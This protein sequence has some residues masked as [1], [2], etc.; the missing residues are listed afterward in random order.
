MASNTPSHSDHQHYWEFSPPSYNGREIL[1]Q[2]LFWALLVKSNILIPLQNPP[3]DQVKALGLLRKGLKEDIHSKPFQF[4]HILIIKTALLLYP[5]QYM[6]VLQLVQ[7]NQNNNPEYPYNT[8]NYILNIPE[9]PQISPNT[10]KT[11]P[12]IPTRFPRLP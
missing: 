2:S 9:Y 11:Y 1:Y 8:F 7:Q 3:E 10:P 4:L 5:V 6:I 12:Q